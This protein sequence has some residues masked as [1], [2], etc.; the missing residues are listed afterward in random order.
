MG[1]RGGSFAGSRS[2][3]K[4]PR[5][6]NPCGIPGNAITEQEFLDLRGVG[7]PMSGY[8][9]DKLRG[10]RSLKTTQG[11]NRFNAAVLQ[12]NADYQ[13]ER[14]NARSEY[15]QLV[16]AGKIRDKTPVE[17]RLTTAHGNPNSTATQAARRMLAKQ[18]IDWKTGKKLAG[19]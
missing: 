11:Q 6:N 18:G 15:R 3:G 16:A 12:A 19:N 2:A 4:I 14:D 8:S 17:K 5:L 7:D 10:N 9:V 13:Q 1:G